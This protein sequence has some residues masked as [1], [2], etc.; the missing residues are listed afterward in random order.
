VLRF[1][2]VD[3]DTFHPDERGLPF[4][5][6]GVFIDWRCAMKKPD[7]RLTTSVVGWLVGSVGLLVLFILVVKWAWNSFFG[8]VLGF[9][10]IDWGQTLALCFW[11]MLVAVVYVGGKET[12][13]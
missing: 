8:E 3:H 9:H 7:I 2:G 10:L 6:V 12:G 13:K 4:R 11:I 1:T 5:L